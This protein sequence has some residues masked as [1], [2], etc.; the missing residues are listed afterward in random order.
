MNADQP[1]LVES[2]RV[3]NEAR[4]EFR[5]REALLAEIRRIE[6]KRS[7]RVRKEHRRFPLSARTTAFFAFILVFAL[8]LLIIRANI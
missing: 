2:I 6:Q 5:S 3:R 1:K 8:A 4:Q 7:K